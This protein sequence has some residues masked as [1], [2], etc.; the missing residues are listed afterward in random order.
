M[1]EHIPGAVNCVAD[2]ISR[3]IVFPSHCTGSSSGGPA[4]GGQV[5]G[6]PAARLG[7]Q[8]LDQTVQDNFNNGIAA[9]TRAV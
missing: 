5:V 4:G 2:A 7:L 3:D 1:A 9:Y 6:A 8:Q